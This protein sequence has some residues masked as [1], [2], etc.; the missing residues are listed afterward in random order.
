MTALGQLSTRKLNQLLIEHIDLCHYRLDAWILGLANQRLIEQRAEEP[1]GIHL[2]AFGW[3]ENLR[4]GGE[5]EI[6][7]EVPSDLR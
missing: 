6:A 1:T 7:Q 4:P 5:R 2:G 3:V